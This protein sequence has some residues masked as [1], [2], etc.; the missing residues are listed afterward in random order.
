[1]IWN[2][3]YAILES[4]EIKYGKPK[5]VIRLGE[6]LVLWRSREGK[7]TC[8]RDKC[9]HR[10]VALS[11]GKLVCEDSEIQCPFHGLQFNQNGKCTVIPSRGKNTPVPSNFKV[12]SYQT[13]EKHNFIWIWWGD[14]QDEYP[15]IPWFDDVD[16]EFHYFTST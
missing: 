15:E 12:E 9:A 7:I 5:G 4:N 8:L 1:M 11:K 10:G 16:D 14:A 2:Q 6:R 13:R 3:W